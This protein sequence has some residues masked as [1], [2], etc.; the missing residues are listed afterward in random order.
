MI[1]TM[2]KNMP[3]KSEGSKKQNKK[4]IESI[5]NEND[6]TIISIVQITM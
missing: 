1:A 5:E 4:N 2:T 3:K 6:A